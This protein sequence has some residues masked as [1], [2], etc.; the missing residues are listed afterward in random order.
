MINDIDN[1]DKIDE[2]TNRQR[3]MGDFKR[4]VGTSDSDIEEVDEEAENFKTKEIEASEIKPLTRS[5]SESRKSPSSNQMEEESATEE[6][7]ETGN[8]GQ[9]EDQSS[10]EEEDTSQQS[11]TRS[12]PPSRSSSKK[13][14]SVKN[15][16]VKP[17]LTKIDPC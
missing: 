9:N 17:F 7:S 2:S 11:I 16:K 3:T 13:F 12:V 6:E 1:Y 8:T 10:N 5:A 4:L 15:Q 14:R